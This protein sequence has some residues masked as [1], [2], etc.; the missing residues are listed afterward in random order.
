MSQTCSLPLF[1]GVQLGT[2]LL[3]LAFLPSTSSTC[4]LCRTASPSWLQVPCW[5]MSS[6]RRMR[7]GRL[8]AYRFDGLQGPT[9]RGTVWPWD[10]LAVPRWDALPGAPPPHGTAPKPQYIAPRWGL[11]GSA[12]LLHIAQHPRVLRCAP[13][14]ARVSESPGR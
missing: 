5:L 12:H 13:N 4:P 2:V 8:T 9:G 14:F 3:P 6:N 7:C 10:G 11:S 1:T